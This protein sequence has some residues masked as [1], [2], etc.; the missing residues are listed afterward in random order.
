MITIFRGIVLAMVLA[1][2]P[3]FLAMAA[4]SS[5]PTK[6]IRIINPFSP[7]GAVDVVSRSVAQK[8]NESWGQ[9]V[10]VD[11]RPGAGTTIGT[12]MV[13]HAAP[14]G[15]TLLLTSAVIATNVTLYPESRDPLKALAPLVL[16]VQAPFV[17]A[18]H[19]SV[20]AKSVHEFINLA[21]AKPRQIAYGSAGAGTTTHLMLELFKLMANVDMLHVPYKGGAPA[22][23]ALLSGEV[24]ATFLPITVVLPQARAGKLR[25]LGISSGKRAELAPELP[26]VSES[27]LPGFDPVGWYAMFAPAGTPDHIVTTLNTE[28]NRILKLP[29]LHE[30]FL[31]NGMLPF[32]GTP[33]ALADYLKMEISRWGKVIREAKIKPE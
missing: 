22:L 24:Q 21:Q 11:N 26:T 17:L 32:G 25:M 3:A 19:P 20:P 12:E 7:G 1:F 30:R 2:G 29:D 33:A 27:G 16:V 31:A 5:Y 8:M 18:V 13:I 15:Y 4:E 6:A 14:D 9:G 28:I 10:V 23:N